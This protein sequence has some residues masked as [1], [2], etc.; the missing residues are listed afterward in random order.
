MK[1]MLFIASMLFTVTR[2][3]S[4]V[5]A[6]PPPVHGTVT[7]INGSQVTVR[8]AFGKESI[9][10]GNGVN[11]RVGDKV[12]YHDGGITAVD[13]P[14]DLSKPAKPN[15]PNPAASKS[16]SSAL[17]VTKIS[18][19]QITVVDASGKVSIV[20]G[21]AAGHKV[22]DKVLIGGGR[23]STWLNPQPE[24]PKPSNPN[25]PDPRAS[26]INTSG[27]VQTK[28]APFTTPELPPPPP[29]NEPCRNTRPAS[30]AVTVF[31]A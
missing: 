5:W 20:K 10:K 18:G 26:K 6:A 17:T 9:V 30:E 7:K 1:R 12:L 2:A 23:I 31:G 27:G 14:S 15:P 22:G 28:S 4:Y 24:P 21:D 16:N 3:S 8:D 11:C 29:K 19:D 25:P 13:S